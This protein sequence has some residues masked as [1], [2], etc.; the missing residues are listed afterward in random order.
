MID[1][2]LKEIMKDCEY[3]LTNEQL[4]HIGR[5]MAGYALAAMMDSK[6]TLEAIEI[7][8]KAYSISI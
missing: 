2:V 3:L 6:V 8:E 7:T 4:E 1:E 5:H